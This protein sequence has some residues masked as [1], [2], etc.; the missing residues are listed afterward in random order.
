MK[1][2][3]VPIKYL[4]FFG[5]GGGG[6]ASFKTKNNKKKTYSLKLEYYTQSLSGHR[7]IFSKYFFALS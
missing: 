6:G 4:Y 2:V 7:V 5:G 1:C 3:D